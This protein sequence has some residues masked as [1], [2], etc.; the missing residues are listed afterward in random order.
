MSFPGF[1]TLILGVNNH[2]L[3]QN[4]STITSQP[5]ENHPGA[6]SN[7]QLVMEKTL[8]ETNGSPL[9]L[10]HSQKEMSSSNHFQGLCLCYF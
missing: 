1:I 3:E 8:P 4:K 2:H 7:H 10:G 9:K 6:P 5:H